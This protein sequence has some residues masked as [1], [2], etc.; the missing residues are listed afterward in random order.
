M[1]GNSVAYGLALNLP[2]LQLRSVAIASVEIRRL[3]KRAPERMQLRAS[4]QNIR[5]GNMYD[6]IG[7]IHGRSQHLV[8]L[9]VLM[10]KRCKRPAKSPTEL[11]H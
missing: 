2:S 4:R 7:D 6:V 8:A 11:Q 1:L 5:A 10:V 3:R 9:L